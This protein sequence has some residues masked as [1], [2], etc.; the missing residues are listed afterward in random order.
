MVPFCAFVQHYI[1][2]VRRA[3]KVGMPAH[4]E[5]HGEHI[6]TISHIE[7]HAKSQFVQSVVDDHIKCEWKSRQGLVEV[8]RELESGMGG[9][10]LS[11][12][13]TEFLPMHESMESIMAGR[14]SGV[15]I[16]GQLVAA[17]E[18]LILSLCNT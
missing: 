16:E 7:M 8:V 10:Y 5:R 2:L 17:I 3:G 15:L 4:V 12:S 6:H 18:K 11:P 1:G 14:V 9:G 13:H